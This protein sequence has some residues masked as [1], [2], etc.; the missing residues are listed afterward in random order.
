MPILTLQVLNPGTADFDRMMM[1]CV[2]TL[3]SFFTLTLELKGTF[4]GG[5]QKT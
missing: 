2:K 4:L 5:A 3:V 1:Q